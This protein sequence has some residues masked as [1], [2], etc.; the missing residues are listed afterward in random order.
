MIMSFVRSLSPSYFSGSATRLELVFHTSKSV[1]SP[2][3]AADSVL[4]SDG[5]VDEATKKNIPK[6]FS[7]CSS[8]CSILTMSCSFHLLESLTRPKMRPLACQW[9]LL[10]DGVMTAIFS[11]K[12]PHAILK[13]DRSDLSTY[14]VK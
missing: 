11:C 14:G 1:S 7:F 8:A 3:A 4:H 12:K 5:T 9:I 2:A 13:N 6:C 10:G